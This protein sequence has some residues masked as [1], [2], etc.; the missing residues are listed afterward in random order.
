MKQE[1]FENLIESLQ[2]IDPINLKEENLDKQKVIDWAINIAQAFMQNDA[3][4]INQDQYTVLAETL[5]SLGVLTLDEI[6]ALQ[7]T[8]KKGNIGTM[9]QE[10]NA[11]FPI[12][13]FAQ[14]LNPESYLYCYEKTFS[15][16]KYAWMA[17]WIKTQTDKN[18]PPAPQR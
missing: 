7:A 1:A 15:G 13:A 8:K 11:L 14:L 10:T 12:N 17:R 4:Y 16:G 9:L 6:K 5:R 3:Q 2:K 18:T